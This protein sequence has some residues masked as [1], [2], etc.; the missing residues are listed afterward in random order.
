V[1]GLGRTVATIANYQ[2]GIVGANEPA[3]RDLITRTVYDAA[4]RRT[5]MIDPAGNTTALAYD[6]QDRLIAVTEHAVSGSCT[7]SPCNVITQYQYDRAGNRTA[8]L[9]AN[10]HVRRFSYDAADQNGHALPLA[11]VPNAGQ[12]DASVRFQAHRVDG[13]VLFFASQHI[14]LAL[15]KTRHGADT[16]AP[17]DQTEARDRAVVRVRFIGMQRALH[18]CAGGKSEPNSLAL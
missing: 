18:G 12:S 9:D 5:Q 11:F 13:G 14:V 2:D 6:Q 15:P 3:D 7:Q 10:G 8:I 17:P 1:D 16:D 4:G